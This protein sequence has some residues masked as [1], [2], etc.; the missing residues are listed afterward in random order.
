[1]MATNRMIIDLQDSNDH[2]VALALQTLAEISTDDM[3]RAL[4]IEVSKVDL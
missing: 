1:M 4:A 3:C 2:I